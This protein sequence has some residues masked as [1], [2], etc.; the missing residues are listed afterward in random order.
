ME[1]VEKE[2]PVIKREFGDIFDLTQDDRPSRPAK[3]AA[4]VIDLTDN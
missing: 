4:V 2:R 3:R 1:R